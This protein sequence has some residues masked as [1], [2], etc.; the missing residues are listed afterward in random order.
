MCE[1][2]TLEYWNCMIS[3]EMCLGSQIWVWIHLCSVF[4]KKALES[5]RSKRGFVLMASCCFLGT[6]RDVGVLKKLDATIISICWELLKYDSI[7]KKRKYVKLHI[8]SG[9]II[10]FVSLDG[11]KNKM[12]GSCLKRVCQQNLVGLGNGS[13]YFSLFCS[14]NGSQY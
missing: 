7:I 10:F 4:I 9:L 8:W 3:D 5:K 6:R 14:T 11:E 13:T 1:N 12:K 2:R